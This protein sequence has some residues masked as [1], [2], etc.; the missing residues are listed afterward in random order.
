MTVLARCASTLAVALLL[1][2]G[3][4][5][6]VWAAPVAPSWRQHLS[7]DPAAQKHAGLE[8]CT[9][10]TGQVHVVVV[11]LQSPGVGLEYV[12]AEGLNKAG[13][14][15]ECQDVNTP[16][17]GPVRGGCADRDKSAHYP[18][19]SA[20]Y[21]VLALDRAVEIARNRDANVAAVINSDYGAGTQGSPGQ[22]R[23]H[24]PEGLTVVRGVRLDGPANGDKDINAINRPWLAVSRSAPLRA[25]LGQLA[26]DDG[27]KA[28]WIYT[29][30]GG[31][32]WLIRG[33]VIQT[34]DIKVCR[35][36]PGS[37]YEGAVQTAVGLSQDRRWLF[38]MVDARKGKLIDMAQFMSDQLAAWDAIKFDG[39][40]SSQLW[41]SGQFISRGDG[42]QL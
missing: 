22:F 4:G 17:N 20:Y 6:S 37:C 10:T 8:Y 5:S 42:R 26:Q 3:R 7:C 36:C 19:G 12:I 40:G 41:Y 35:N 11:D 9:A 14:F 16:Q 38:L 21:P 39:G 13:Q 32:P 31:G 25:E 18:D 29:G 1:W 27:G 33:G 30:V 15:G 28:D 2:I 24:G 34:E 23:G